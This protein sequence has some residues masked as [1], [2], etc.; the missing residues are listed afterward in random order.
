MRIWPEGSQSCGPALAAA[1]QALQL[2]YH[3]AENTFSRHRCDHWSCGGTNIIFVQESGRPTVIPLYLY[4]VPGACGN[5]FLGENLRTWPEGS[6]SCGPALAAALQVL[7]LGY[8]SVAE[9]PFADIFLAP[10]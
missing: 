4:L 1:L 10:L 5:P 8:H 2:G 3:V 7:Q 9:N 6:Q